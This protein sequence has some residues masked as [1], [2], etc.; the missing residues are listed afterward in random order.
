MGLW[1]RYHDWRLGYLIKGYP[2]LA[3]F[4]RG[5]AIQRIEAC[6][7]EERA[8]CEPW[9]S[10]AE[11]AAITFFIAVL[12]SSLFRARLPFVIPIGYII[13]FVGRSYFSKRVKRRVN[14]KI[15]AER[16]DG[17]LT[18]CLDCGYDLRASPARCPECGAPARVAP[19]AK[20][21]T[22]PFLP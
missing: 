12:V 7:R 17:R 20:P 19:P 22:T 9:Y 10:L 8:L 11:W 15:E 16:S 14:A 13:Y 3:A 1:K 4:D 2:A 5:E 6:R 18:T 21:R